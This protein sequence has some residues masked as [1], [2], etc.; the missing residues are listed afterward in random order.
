MTYINQNTDL[1]I[2]FTDS[3]KEVL[4]L[5]LNDI[6]EKDKRIEVLE[7]ACDKKVFFS[8]KPKYCKRYFG[9]EENKFVILNLNRNTPRKRLDI[10]ISAFVYFLKKLKANEYTTENI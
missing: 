2:A 7:H 4:R 8:L 9:I 10:S 3:W 6:N 5:A 1:Y